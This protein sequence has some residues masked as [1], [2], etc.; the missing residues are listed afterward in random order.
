MQCADEMISEEQIDGF[1]VRFYAQPEEDDPA[2]HFDTLGVPELQKDVDAINEGRLL[3]FMVRCVASKAGVDLGHDYLGGCAYST[4]ADFLTDGGYS[5]DMR[6]AAVE[7][8]KAKLA[9]LCQ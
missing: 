3:W 9:E 1:T 7:A 8:A 5:A 6:R 4:Y 2:D